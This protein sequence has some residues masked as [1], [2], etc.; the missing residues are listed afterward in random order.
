MRGPEWEEEGEGGMRGGGGRRERGDYFRKKGREKEKNF[1]RTLC[2]LH[3]LLQEE[4]R[5]TRG[6]KEGGKGQRVEALSPQV[7]P[8]PH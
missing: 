1:A 3:V 7:Q 8:P 6:Q 5:E 4:R 2:E